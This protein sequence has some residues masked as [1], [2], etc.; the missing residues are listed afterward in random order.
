MNKVYISKETNP[1]FNIALENYLFN[2]VNEDIILY[3]WLND[4]SVIIGRN[5]NLFAETN[6]DYLEE[7]NIYPVRRLSGG[8]AVYHD[9]GNL[10]FTLI[11][12]EDK[13]DDK[14]LIEFLKNVFNKLGIESEFSGRNDLLYKGKKFSGHAYYIEDDN[15]MYHGT[16]MINVDLEE[17]TRSLTPSNLKL[18]SKGIESVR[19]RVINLSE[20]DSSIDIDK[21]I[22]SF[23]KT[24]DYKDLE[25]IDNNDITLPLAE[26]L[27]SREWLFGESPN[28]EIHLERSCKIGNISI[29]LS[30]DGDNISKASISTDSL[31]VFNFTD[32]EKQLIDKKFDKKEIWEI[33]YNYI[34]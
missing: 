33:I 24:F 13:S 6:I 10:N 34:N 23:L 14:K 2:N 9:L 4:K 25:Y 11:M 32:I 18:K 12:K 21:L 8:G 27:S 28:Y 16:I 30:I 31:K 17:L 29:D 20:I 5:Q 1:Y 7:N 3:L 22:E 26:K 15:Y 19:S